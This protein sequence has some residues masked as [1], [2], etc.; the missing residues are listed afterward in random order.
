MTTVL[1]TGATGVLGREV[2]SALQES[3]A[4]VRIASRT[5]RPTSDRGRYEWATVDYRTGAGLA[6]AGRGVDAVVH[7]AS[8]T[9]PGPGAA[10]DEDITRFLVAALT[11]ATHVVL[12]SI[13]GVDA[14]PLGY[15]QHKLA[16][17][18]VVRD[19]GLP[20]TVLRTTQF[21]GLVCGILRGLSA[22]PLIMPLPPGIRL[23]PIDPA[24]VGRRLAD[25]ALGAPASRVPDL[26]GPDIFSVDDLARRYLSATGR[27][28]RIVDL[29]VRGRIVDALRTGVNLAPDNRAGGRSFD[30]YLAALPKR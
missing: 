1:V 29:P 5:P 6:D 22:A 17:E 11:P 14:I 4:R 16:A 13:V 3:G 30:E 24:V 25:L 20:W 10:A 27:S 2:V 7:C 12:I 19:S 23:Q 9:R 8:S 18:Q 15:Y 21:H 26:G 28:R